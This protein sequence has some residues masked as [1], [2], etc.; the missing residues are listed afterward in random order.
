MTDPCVFF[1]L[2][3]LFLILAGYALRQDI[4][5]KHGNGGVSVTVQ[6]GPQSWSY[7]YYTYGALAVI[8]LELINTTEAF[9]GHKTLITVADLSLLVYMCFFNGWFRNKIVSFV[10]ASKGKLE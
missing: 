1:L 7:F 9:R 10:S 8:L 3:I 5:S 2:Q 6:R 4:R